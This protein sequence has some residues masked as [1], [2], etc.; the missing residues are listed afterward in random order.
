MNMIEGKAEVAKF[1]SKAFKI[2]ERLDADS[3]VDLLSKTIISVASDKH[4]RHPVITGVT[5]NLFRATANYIDHTFFF[6]CRV[7]EEQANACCTRQKT[8][9]V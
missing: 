4:H 2:M 5:R 9:M 7:R 8:D 1:E 6:S 3:N